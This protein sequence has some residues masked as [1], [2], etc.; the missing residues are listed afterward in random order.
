MF[1]RISEAL[2]KNKGQWRY[3]GRR[4]KGYYN[5]VQKAIITELTLQ[6]AVD[7]PH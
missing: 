6:W 3:K 4:Y 7:Q 5:I 1:L 2:N